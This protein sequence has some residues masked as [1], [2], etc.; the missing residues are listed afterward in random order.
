MD[1][2]RDEV[3]SELINQ[4]GKYNP[5][6]R[7]VNVRIVEDIRIAIDELATRFLAIAGD[8]PV[9]QL[10]QGSS[11]DPLIFT[12]AAMAVDAIHRETGG[13]LIV[14]RLPISKIDDIVHAM[15]YHHDHLLLVLRLQ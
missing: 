5:N 11:F 14:N 12:K 13:H 6:D 2:L 8:Q 10:E 4:A 1:T 3:K 7:D 9:K 15:R